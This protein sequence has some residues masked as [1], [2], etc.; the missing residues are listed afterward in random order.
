M[1]ENDPL[2]MEVNYNPERRQVEIIVDQP[3][4]LYLIEMLQYL[5]GHNFSGAHYHIDDF[6]GLTGNVPHLVIAKRIRGVPPF[7]KLEEPHTEG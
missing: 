2:D 1:T 3:T 6:N 5:V 4:L 7:V